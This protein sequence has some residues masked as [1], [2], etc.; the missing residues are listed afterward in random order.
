MANDYF[1]MV[2]DDMLDGD[3]TPSTTRVNLTKYVGGDKC[4]Q[5]TVTRNGIPSFMGLTQKE[6]ALLSGALLEGGYGNITATG[7]EETNFNY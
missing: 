4:V 5:I 7:Y 3:K 6:C 2:S 1:E